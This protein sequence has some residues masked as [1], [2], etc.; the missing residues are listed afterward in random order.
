[1]KVPCLVDL[2]KNAPNVNY[3]IILRIYDALDSLTLSFSTGKFPFALIAY[4]EVSKQT[5]IYE[6]E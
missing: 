6:L 3:N 2:R 4:H 5:N 1:M